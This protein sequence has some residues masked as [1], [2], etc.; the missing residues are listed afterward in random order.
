LIDLI[1][2]S[3]GGDGDL[4]ELII[5]TRYA[6]R[7]GRRDWRAGKLHAL[8]PVFLELGA[9]ASLVYEALEHARDPLRSF[10]LTKA[11]GLSRSA[12]YEALETLGAFDLE[13]QRGGRWTV[14][15]GTDLRLLAE[16]LG[17]LETIAD[18][19]QRHRFE[20]AAYRRGP[21]YRRPPHHHRRSAVLASG[22]TRTVAGPGHRDSTGRPATDPGR[23]SHSGLIP[24][25]CLLGVLRSAGYAVASLGSMVTW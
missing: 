24:Q 16:Q 22:R 1:Q 25:C 5:P 18:Q 7:A 15:A 21:A 12:V 4:Y 6:G 11:T 2:D 8:R 17:V 23:L 14:V 3:R 20:R 13:R 19:V 10:D 9:P